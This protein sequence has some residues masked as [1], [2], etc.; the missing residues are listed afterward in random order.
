[1][2]CHEKLCSLI[3]F[4]LTMKTFICDN[5]KSVS[6]TSTDGHGLYSSGSVFIFKTHPPQVR[7]VDC[8]ASETYHQNHSDYATS[9][10][11]LSCVLRL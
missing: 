11:R 10:P 2:L 3:L 7:L 6:E 5:H 9:K 4:F 8:K 1:M